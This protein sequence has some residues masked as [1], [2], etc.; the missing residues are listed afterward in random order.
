MHALNAY[1]WVRNID[2]EKRPGKASYDILYI[3][4]ILLMKVKNLNLKDH[5]TKED[6]YGKIPPILSIDVC[7][8]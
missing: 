1:T 4:T 7:K 2:P 6:I 5:S 8:M 3:Y